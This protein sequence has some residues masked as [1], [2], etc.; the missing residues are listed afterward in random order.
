MKQLCLLNGTIK[1]MSRNNTPDIEEV[2][3]I[4]FKR[5]KFTVSFQTI[6][7]IFKKIKDYVRHS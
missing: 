6:K 2:T 4:K 7:N 1:L 3:P 5:V